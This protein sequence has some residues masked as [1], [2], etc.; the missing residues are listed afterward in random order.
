MPPLNLPAAESGSVV[1]RGLDRLATALEAVVDRIGGAM[2]WL[3]LAVVFLLFVQN[4]LR[5]YF[6]Q[7]QFLAN[8]MG[9]LCHAAVFMIGVAYA[10][11]WDRQVRV[12]LFYRDM[13]GRTKA[14]VNLL[15]TVFLL[16]PWLA[17]V[18]WDSV[19]TVVESIRIAERFPETG[20]PGF[21]VFKS[22]LLAFAVTLGLQAT[23]VIARSIVAILG[24]KAR[25]ATGAR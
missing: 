12:D 3:V 20:S 11:R 1:L 6:G 15:G 2:A 16:L 21:F 8:D 25:G 14:V 23:A 10:W 7:G 9:Q 19:P 5:E 24:A 22:I 4:P 13:G 17:F 18:T